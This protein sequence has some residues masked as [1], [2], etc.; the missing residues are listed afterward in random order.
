MM[1]TANFKITAS[2]PSNKEIKDLPEYK[3]LINK[4]SKLIKGSIKVKDKK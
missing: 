1:Y 2:R 3:A 4:I